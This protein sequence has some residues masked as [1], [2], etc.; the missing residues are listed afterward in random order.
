M[1]AAEHDGV[2]PDIAVVSK[3]LSGGY[4]PITAVAVRPQL[5]DGFSADPII[6]GLRYGH[7]SSG[8]A[9]ACA[10][11]L[12][13]LDVLERERLPERADRHGRD[14]LS[15]LEPLAGKGFATDVRGLGLVVTLEAGSVEAATA[16][17]VAA[18]GRGLLL[19]QQGPNVMVVPP[20]IIDEEGLSAITDGIEE[21][22]A[23]LA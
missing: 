13:T 15:R 8:H 2:E 20:L 12:A 10:A 5:H 3:G 21:S 1:F 22:L 17:V 14:L 11:A 23:E 19:R 16:L 4:V 7:T 6:G 9:V 18:R